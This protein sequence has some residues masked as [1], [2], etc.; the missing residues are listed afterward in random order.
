MIVVRLVIEVEVVYDPEDT[1]IIELEIKA[2]G[3]C[4]KVDKRTIRK[5]NSL[6]RYSLDVNMESLTWNK[7][8][9]S[10]TVNKCIAEHIENN[11]KEIY[12]A[13]CNNL[14]E[15]YESKT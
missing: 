6:E 7:K 3:R 8:E 13:L 9:Y 11:K 1:D 14:I 2:Y 12:Y 15:K 4:K 5:D 10:T